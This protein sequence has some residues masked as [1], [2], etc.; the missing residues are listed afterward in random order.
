M[1]DASPLPITLKTRIGRT[2]NTANINEI[3][4]AAQQAGADAITVHARY[5]CNRHKGPADWHAL[6]QLK[7]Y[8]RIPLI[9]NGGADS[10][11]DAIQMLHQTRAD[12]IMI[13]RAALGN[14][15]IF[16][17]IQAALNGDTWS[18]PDNATRRALILEHAQRTI[19][20]SG[21]ALKTRRKSRYTAE[22]AGCRLFRAHL[23]KYLAGMPGLKQAL[24]QVDQID[25]LQHIQQIIEKL[26]KDS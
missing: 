1:K 25:S 13:G 18:P 20:M 10:A 19:E 17:E 21:R 24:L 3:A 23:V 16:E 7:K 11:Q 5:A 4:D 12:A 14:P 8:L 2:P 26:L 15:W 6:R 9:A 22:Q